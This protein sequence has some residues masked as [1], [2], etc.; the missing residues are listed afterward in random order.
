MDLLVYTTQ[1][2][3]SHLTRRFVHAVDKFDHASLNCTVTIIHDDFRNKGWIAPVVV[4]FSSSIGGALLLSCHRCHK[5]GSRYNGKMVFCDLLESNRPAIVAL[6]NSNS[7]MI[8]QVND[9]IVDESDELQ[10]SSMLKLLRAR[11]GSIFQF[12]PV[13]YTHS[14]HQRVTEVLRC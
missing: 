12:H 2:H 14:K 6:D 8:E 13:R 10:V 9:L 1:E 3:S 5:L 4:S 7:L 11:L